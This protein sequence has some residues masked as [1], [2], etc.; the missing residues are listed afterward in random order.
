MSTIRADHGMKA[1]QWYTKDKKENIYG[2]TTT[3]FDLHPTAGERDVINVITTH[4][5]VLDSDAR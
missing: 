3:C 2:K 4:C 1:G 5:I